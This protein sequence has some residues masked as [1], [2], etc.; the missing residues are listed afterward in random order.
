MRIAIGLF[1][2]K[3]GIEI[4]AAYQ[5]GI[6]ASVLVINKQSLSTLWKLVKRATSNMVSD[7]FCLVAYNRINQMAAAI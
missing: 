7:M 5:N 4:Q 1:K 3:N 2:N 6:K